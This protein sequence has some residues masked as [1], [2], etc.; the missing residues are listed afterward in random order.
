VRKSNRFLNI[1][2][3]MLC[4]VL[5]AALGGL[6]VWNKKQTRKETQRLEEMADEAK[7]ADEKALKELKKKEKETAEELREKAEE[8]DEK[9]E[10]EKA[11]PTSTPAP[12]KREERKA[13]GIACWGDDLLTER[14]TAQYSYMAVLQR[15]LQEN[16]YT[17]PVANKTIQGGGTL[18]MMKR[19]GV[20]DDVIQGYIAAHEKVAN[21]ATLYVT[22]NG[23]RD[24][25]EEE[26]VREDVNYIP[27]IFMGY[28]GGWNH[29]PNELAQ[30]Q[31]HILKTFEQQE[32]FIVVGT[33]PL[34]GSVD[35]A[36]LDAALK[37]KWGEHYI[38]LAEVTPQP[39]STYEAQEAMAQAVFNKMTELN[40]IRKQ[41]GSAQ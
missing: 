19:A 2:L 24:F 11:A 12:T 22:E 32:Q 28:Y 27:V 39:S 18:S 36:S 38:S 4:I 35:S 8:E 20:G 30:Q 13:E 15:L 26:L 25:T 7:Q 10:K 31:E 40:Y 3:I 23:V 33:R 37:Q 17:L 34:D 29:D 14:D 16:G 5:V 21:G 1:L 6:V 9:K 41:A